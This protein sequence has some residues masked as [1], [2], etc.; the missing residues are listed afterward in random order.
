MVSENMRQIIQNLKKS[1]RKEGR[2]LP[3]HTEPDVNATTW[4]VISV[5]P[6]Y[7]NTEKL[8]PWE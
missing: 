4:Q 3:L 1:D 7:L 8:P 5:H 2:L 6:Q